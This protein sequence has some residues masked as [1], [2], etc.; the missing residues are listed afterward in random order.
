MLSRGDIDSLLIPREGLVPR[1]NIRHIK[2][3][4]ILGDVHFLDEYIISYIIEC[5]SGTFLNIWPQKYTVRD[6][7]GCQL[8]IGFVRVVNNSK[9]ALTISG[10]MAQEDLFRNILDLQPA[11]ISINI[12]ISDMMV[13]NISWNK[14]EVSKLCSD[15]IHELMCY[16]YTYLINSGFRGQ[17]IESTTFTINMLP[18]YMACDATRQNK[19]TIKQT[20]QHSKNFGTNYCTYTHSEYKILSDVVNH[21]LHK[22]SELLFN[23]FNCLLINP[24]PRWEFQGSHVDPRTGL[25]HFHQEMFKNYFSIMGRIMCERRFCTLGFMSTRTNRKADNHLIH[26]CLK[27]YANSA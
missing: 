17:F 2:V 27:E 9:S 20:R 15:K 5:E 21:K 8:G 1:I 3:L 22:G 25:P 7:A 4:L 24:T 19:L 10:L 13:E 14:N 6:N 12:G 18:M 26:G 16:L 23:K 11:V